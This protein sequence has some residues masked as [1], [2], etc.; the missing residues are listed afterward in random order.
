MSNLQVN[1]TQTNTLQYYDYPDNLL[2]VAIEQ[3]ESIDT[4]TKMT[5]ANSTLLLSPSPPNDI[6]PLQY[7]I[8][9]NMSDIVEHLLLDIP[10]IYTP[11][12]LL[13]MAKFAIQKDCDNC[14]VYFQKAIPANDVDWYAYEIGLLFQSHDIDLSP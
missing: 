11:E 5:A 8:A 10:A 13:D 4:I 2:L 7:A 9:Y 12:Y 3:R 1:V 14:L 6:L